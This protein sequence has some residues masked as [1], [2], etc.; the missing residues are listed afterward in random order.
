MTFDTYIILWELIT[1]PDFLVIKIINHGRLTGF[2]LTVRQVIDAVGQIVSESNALLQFSPIGEVSFFMA[3]RRRSILTALSMSDWKE[4]FFFLW[5]VA[6]SNRTDYYLLAFV[7][8]Q[9]FNSRPVFYIQK[10]SPRL[11]MT[12]KPFHEA[13]ISVAALMC[14]AHIGINGVAAHRQRWFRL[15]T[16]S[17]ESSAPHP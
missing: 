3:A 10:G 16:A 14:A 11:C 9:I 1:L 7:L 15:L 17:A 4:V 12:G 5:I 13:G 6:V 2:T 8:Q